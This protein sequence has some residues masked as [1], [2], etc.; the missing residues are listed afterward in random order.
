V[1]VA[2]SRKPLRCVAVCMLASH[3]ERTPASLFGSLWG[4]LCVVLGALPCGVVCRVV[5][6]VHADGYGCALPTAYHTPRCWSQ[7]ACPSHMVTLSL[8]NPHLVAKG[9][10]SEPAVGRARLGRNAAF[11]AI[12]V[13]PVRGGKEDGALP[14]ASHNAALR[15]NQL[16][17]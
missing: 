7:N 3:G 13:G 10:R 12:G 8:S 2:A 5:L 11:R 17:A 16:G 1:A 9:A 14:G 15:T 4:A 6:R